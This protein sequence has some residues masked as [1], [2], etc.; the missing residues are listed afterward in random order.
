MCTIAVYSWTDRYVVQACA[1]YGPAVFLLI[2]AAVFLLHNNDA[3]IRRSGLFSASY[4]I[5]ART[6]EFTTQQPDIA[7]KQFHI[8]LIESAEATGD[9]MCQTSVN[10]AALAEMDRS[11]GGIP[12]AAKLVLLLVLCLQ[13]ATYTML[14]R[15]RCARAWHNRDRVYG[16]SLPADIYPGY[17]FAAARCGGSSLLYIRVWRL[18][19]D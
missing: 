3:H 2:A 17:R 15:Y 18:M 12:K 19:K 11:S 9:K 13:N 6:P 4:P 16:A 1:L 10:Q 7:S 5:I 8:F 14:R